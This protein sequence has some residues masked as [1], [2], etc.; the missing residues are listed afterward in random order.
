MS[1][2]SIGS[3]KG[4]TTNNSFGPSI[5]KRAMTNKKIETYLQISDSDFGDLDC[6]DESDKNDKKLLRLLFPPYSR[7]QLL[8]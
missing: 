7:F 2:S 1:H 5:A 6:D 3:K 4:K 8:N